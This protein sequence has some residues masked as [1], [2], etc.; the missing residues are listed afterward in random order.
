MVLGGLVV[1]MMLGNCWS[2][3]CRS[4]CGSSGHEASLSGSRGYHSS[5]VFQEM[6]AASDNIAVS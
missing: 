6:S 4:G 5:E 1:A 2:T 3:R